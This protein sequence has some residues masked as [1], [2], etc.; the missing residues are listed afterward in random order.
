VIKFTLG[1]IFSRDLETVYLLRMNRPDWQVGLLNGV[2]GKV[3]TAE[4]FLSCMIR[5]AREEAGY[6]GQWRQFALLLGE[7]DP[8]GAWQCA[9][10][11]SV[12]RPGAVAPQTCTDEAIE[13]VAVKDMTRILPQMV[14]AAPWLIVSALKVIHSNE[15]ALNVLYL[16]PGNMEN[17]G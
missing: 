2:G 11:W 9:V 1:F 5:E 16:P 12:M 17:E 14:Y 7:D 4:S 15:F 10:F 3:E 8:Y 13:P 6:G